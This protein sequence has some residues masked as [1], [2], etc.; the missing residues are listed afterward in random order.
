M[1]AMLTS[2]AAGLVL[3]QTAPARMLAFGGALIGIQR[4]S[5]WQYVPETFPKLAKGPWTFYGVG[6]GKPVANYTAASIEY[7]EI[8]AWFLDLDR[9]GMPPHVLVSGG[10]PRFPR[11]VAAISATNR[12]YSS[13]FQA[14]LKGPTFKRPV[15]LRQAF[16]VDLDGDGRAEVI[17]AGG[18]A[19]LED[20]LGMKSI[21]Q[22]GPL[23]SAVLLRSVGADG[24]VR[25]TSLGQSLVKTEDDVLMVHEL[26]AIGDVD[27]DGTMEIVVSERMYESMGATLWRFRQGQL[28]KLTQGGFGA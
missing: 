25:T 5:E 28:K 15:T 21:K 27:A 6:I 23:V 8:G 7:G 14:A 2:L 26:C 22:T 11:P 9:A 13:A 17:L 10:P 19:T 16:S 4:G 20:T 1:Q 3:S 24:K 12:T 18:N